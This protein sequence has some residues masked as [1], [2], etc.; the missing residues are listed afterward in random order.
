MDSVERGALAA[1]IYQI[2]LRWRAFAGQPEDEA[3]DS[4]FWVEANDAQ[5]QEL[6]AFRDLGNELMGRG[7]HWIE[8]RASPLEDEPPG[9]H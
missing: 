1:A 7:T 3:R 6:Y 9:T 5:A 2:R 4:S 8:S